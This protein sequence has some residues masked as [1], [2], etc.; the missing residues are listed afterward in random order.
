M[1]P[2]PQVVAGKAVL[3]IDDILTTGATARSMAQVLIRAGAAK[4][5]VATLARARHAFDYG[6]ISDQVN[7]GRDRG[8]DGDPARNRQAGG[9]HPKDEVLPLHTPEG[10]ERERSTKHLF[11]GGKDVAG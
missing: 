8:N 6:G 4:V 2:D 3:V 11:D 1:V 7:S 10:Q 5:W 9:D